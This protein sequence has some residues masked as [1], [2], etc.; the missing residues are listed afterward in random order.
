[1]PVKRTTPALGLPYRPAD[2]TD[3]RHT[4]A[5]A[6]SAQV[7][8]LRACELCL[9]SAEVS[10]TLLCLCH[11]VRRVSGLQP[12]HIVRGAGEAC[13]PGA[14]HLDMASWRAA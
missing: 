8:P 5:A 3:V 1:M 11:E 9:H 10:Q 14:R 7:P 4:W 2:Q 6:L 12:V 13:G